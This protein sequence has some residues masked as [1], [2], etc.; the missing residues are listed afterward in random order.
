MLASSPEAL[1]TSL[2]P[3]HPPPSLFQTT[4]AGKIPPVHWLP[5]PTFFGTSLLERLTGILAV[6]PVI[7]TAFVSAAGWLGVVCVAPARAC[8]HG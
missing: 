8:A 7:M 2:P 3:L 1:M 6:V 4:F 5:D